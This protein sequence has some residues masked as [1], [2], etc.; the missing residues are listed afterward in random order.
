MGS[1][2]LSMEVENVGGVQDDH[3]DITPGVTVLSGENTT[4]RTSLINA[5]MAGF[6]S[7]DAE[8]RTGAEEGYVSL[9]IGSETYTREVNA[10]ESGS[11][12]SGD[13]VVDDVETLEL[14]SFLLRDNDVRQAIANGDDLYDL[15]MRPIDTDQI[16][17]EI[18][19]LQE[20]R[21]NIVARE[22]TLDEKR[23]EIKRLR[24]EIESKEEEQESI[25]S[26]LEEIEGEIDEIDETETESDRLEESRELNERVKELSN[27]EDTL[28]GEIE[29][30]ENQIETR[31]EE[32][33][34]LQDSEFRD[35]DD[36]QDDLASVKDEIASIEGERSDIDADKRVITPLQQFLNQM[37]GEDLSPKQINRVFAKYGEKP[38]TLNLDNEDKNPTDALVEDVDDGVCVL[39]GSKLESG[40]YE[41]MLSTVNKTINSIKEESDSLQDRLA[42]LRQERDDIQDEI[43]TINENKDRIEDLES[44]LEDRRKKLDEKKEELDGVKNDKKEVEQQLDEIEEVVENAEDQTDEL[45][46]LEQEKTQL[47]IKANRLSDQIESNEAEIGELSDDIDQIE[48]EVEEVKPEI[49]SELNELKG[50][51]DSIETSVIEEFNQ[52]MDEIISRL[53]YASIERIWIEKQVKDIRDGRKN[54]EK[55]FFNLNIAREVDGKVTT[56]VIDN[57]SESERVVTA[58]VFAFTGYIV[59]G[60]DDQFPI[61]MMDSVEMIDATRLETLLDYMQ[62]Y[63][64][65]LI[66]TTL[67]EDTDV[68]DIGSVIE[69]KNK[70]SA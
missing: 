39:C 36:L 66:V 5:L 60:V 44:Q 28:Q 32:L 25:Q 17:A 20:R 9:N 33:D 59:H 2:T 8:I 15:V 3:I 24:D 67:P 70:T 53:S 27:K 19:E 26:E 63:I 14:F 18:S 11:Q 51:V 45:R 47:E 65:Y 38:E 34:E 46:N 22:E 10:V 48:T 55:T 4:N 12:W 58:L 29:D 13:S 31:S 43:K 35:V 61:V 62:D 6:G 37:T 30:I 21:E 41:D 56:E 23:D 50:K 64:D 49:E 1:E 42:E 69:R 16:E 7:D 40:H 68:M 54:V 52:Q 57:L